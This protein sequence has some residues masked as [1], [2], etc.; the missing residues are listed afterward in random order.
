MSP[1]KYVQTL[2]SV[3]LHR[4]AD[5]AGLAHWTKLIQETGDFTCVLQG[6]LESPE[7]AALAGEQGSSNCDEEIEKALSLVGRQLRIV[8][9]GAQSLGIGSHP[10]DGLL[11]I[12][13]PQIIGFDPLEQRL[14]ERA[15]A[16]GDSTGNLILLPYAIADG[17]RHILHINDIDATSSL[18]PYNRQH[19][20]CFDH[21][22]ERST[23]NTMEIQTYRL[24]DVLP[25]GPVDLLKLDVQGS[26]LMV[27]RG[28]ENVLHQ[29]AVVHCE[30]MFSPMYL[31][32][33]LFPEICLHLL[34]RNF[35]LLDLLVSHR[36]HYL[37]PSGRKGS[38]RLIWADAVF[39]RNTESAEVSAVQAL[40]AA[41]VY[42]KPTLAEH[43]LLASH[44]EARSSNAS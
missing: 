30:A 14:R 41:S 25:A 20:A 19:N 10:Y 17:K 34:E 28:A 4:H 33:P 9:V 18:F 37:T 22:S 29:T 31:G 16:E 15:E 36:H 39:F 44:K 35:F 42:K 8:D 23:V 6:I 5:P 32:Q 2:Y 21:V 24:D 26:E 13:T 43:L 38:D 27:L 40:I 1:E 11:Q 3:C 7:Y 12:T